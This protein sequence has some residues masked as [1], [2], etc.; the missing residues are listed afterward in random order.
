VN[1]AID[2]ARAWRAG[3]GQI[4]PSSLH[5][6]AKDDAQRIL[7]AMRD[8]AEVT[9]NEILVQL[10]SHLTVT[11]LTATIYRHAMIE[12]GAIEDARA[13]LPYN[14]CPVCGYAFS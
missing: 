11:E 6:L 7:D 9:E 13:R 8:G 12:C 2:Q 3:K 1:T 10:Y 4:S 5:A 14:P